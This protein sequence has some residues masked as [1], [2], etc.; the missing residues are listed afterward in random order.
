MVNR[1][2]FLSGATASATAG[3]VL[4][5]S[6]R[7][8]ARIMGANDRVH[9][10]VMGVNGRGQAHMDALSK[11]PDAS[12]DFL[13]DV[14]SLVLEK[15][16]AEYAAKSK[17]RPKTAGDYR[18]VL[19][20]RAIDAMTVAVPD[21]WHARAAIDGLKAG[22]HVYVEKPV[23]AY[24]REGELMID[25]AARNPK[26][27][28]QYGAQ[29]RSSDVLREFVELARH[30]AL[31]EIYQADTWYS[32]IRTSIG[33]GVDGSAPRNLDWELWQGPAPRRSYRSNV[34]HYNW[35]WFWRWGTGELPNNAMHEL[36]VARWVMGVDFPE[37]VSA[38]GQRRYFRS[39]DWEM[40]D[41]LALELAFRGGKIIRWS[42]HSCNQILEHGRDRGVLIIGDKGSALVDGDFYEIFDLAGKS[43][44]KVDGGT[45]TAT[46]D[47]VGGSN[48][49]VVHFSNFLALVRGTRT[50]PVAPIREGHVSTALC[51][52]G[53]IAYRTGLE[54]HCD[55]VT[56][57]P[58]EP[59]ARQ[60]WSREYAP[61]W[62]LTV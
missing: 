22:K 20:N 11:L 27:V 48:L 10:A 24:P 59:A 43:V 62:E 26:L 19:D 14:D 28:L 55:P 40:Y 25:A 60:L 41:T 17:P 52:L 42:G 38:S 16:A 46:T 54:L 51:H 37:R 18:R 53:N 3:V 35:H 1:R 56:G 4:A 23:C 8:Y 45:R 13:I 34:V 12:I 6:A 39:D 21:H 61:G 30:G 9:L 29:R 47:H 36:D 7:S 15:R 44:S 58:A 49:D 31:G 50:E 2:E 33:V 5:T 32:N 57:I